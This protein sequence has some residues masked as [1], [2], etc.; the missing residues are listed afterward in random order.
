MWSHLAP[1]RNLNSPTCQLPRK[2]RWADFLETAQSGQEGLQTAAAVSASTCSTEI[3]TASLPPQTRGPTPATADHTSADFAAAAGRVTPSY[4]ARG[5]ERPA[6]SV[7][8]I[9]RAQSAEP[10]TLASLVAT[11][12]SGGW[13]Y[14]ASSPLSSSNLAIATLPASHSHSCPGQRS[15]N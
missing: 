7:C 14:T 6:P 13:P 9:V 11:A 1:L 10:A 12:R 3:P 8:G 4:A 15:P 5:I 2:V